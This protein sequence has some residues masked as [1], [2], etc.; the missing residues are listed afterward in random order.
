MLG[1]YNTRREGARRKKGQK[2][3]GWIGGSNKKAE[4]K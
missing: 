1:L 4:E 3:E 2:C